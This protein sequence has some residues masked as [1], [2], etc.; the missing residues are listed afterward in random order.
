MQQDPHQRG[1]KVDR[2]VKY[3]KSVFLS[4][5]KLLINH[6]VGCKKLAPVSRFQM[7]HLPDLYAGLLVV[8]SYSMNAIFPFVLGSQTGIPKAVKKKIGNS[9]GEEGL[10]ILE[11][12]GHEE[13]SILKFLKAR[14]VKRW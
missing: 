4:N 10:T 5:L 12:V 8:S 1:L 11:L 3:K 13:K 14:G 2:S 9:R 7:E 6:L